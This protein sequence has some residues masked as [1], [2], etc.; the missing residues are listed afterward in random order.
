MKNSPIARFETQCN[1]EGANIDYDIKFNDTSRMHCHNFF[2]VFCVL[3]GKYNH[4]INNKK[5][6]ITEGNGYFLAPDCVHKLRG[7]SSQVSRIN[8]VIKKNF[9]KKACNYYS[10]TLYDEITSLNNAKISMSNEFYNKLIS[11][12]ST[13][14]END[15][16]G[17]NSMI[18]KELND[19]KFY[20]GQFDNFSVFAQRS[21]PEI[22]RK[23]SERNITDTIQTF[24]CKF[25]VNGNAP[26]N[27]VDAR[28]QFRRGKR[29]GHIIIRS[30]KQSRDLIHFLCFCRQYYN[31]QG[32]AFLSELL[33]YFQSVDSGH[34]N[35]QQRNVEKTLVVVIQLKR[36]FTV[37][38]FHNLKAAAFKIN[39]NKF[40]YGSFILSN[41]Y[42]FHTVTPS[43]SVQAKLL[44]CFPKMII[45]F[46]GALR[47]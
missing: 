18:E 1:F 9:F 34:H 12:L 23:L 5:E 19:L 47:R 10:D 11:Y 43:L 16:S 38:G 25:L 17:K 45:F 4:T 33:T 3:N 32:T 42:S 7:E 20:L 14:D 6:I 39:N 40:A 26:V 2:E 21:V 41:K 30:D 46:R 29:L 37:F 24:R 27:R 31:S 8:I 28:H 13:R 44:Y 36:L 22:Q 35:I 15:A